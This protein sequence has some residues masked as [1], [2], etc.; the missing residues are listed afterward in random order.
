[1]H[2]WA[3]VNSV[4]PVHSDTGH[5]VLKKTAAVAIVR[6]LLQECD[7]TA[8]AAGYKNMG[9]CI[10]WL[11]NLAAGTNWEE[12]MIAYDLKNRPALPARLF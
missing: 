8:K 1:M 3:W 4:R 11:G 2:Y 7:P 5:P 6:I 10:E 9:P 12:E